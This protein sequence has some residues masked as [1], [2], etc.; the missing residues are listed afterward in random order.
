MIFTCLSVFSLKSVNGKS[1]PIKKGQYIIILPYST[2]TS[3]QNDRDFA[4]LGGD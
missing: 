1:F 4:K 3:P 2:L